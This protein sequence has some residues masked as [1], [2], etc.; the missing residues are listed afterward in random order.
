MIERTRIGCIIATVV[1]VAVL[2]VMATG[3][4]DREYFVTLCSSCPQRFANGTQ[5]YSN[6][7]SH[8]CAKD[9]ICTVD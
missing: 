7:I 8:C 5:D 6:C 9:S 1:I 2:V 3:A 4:A